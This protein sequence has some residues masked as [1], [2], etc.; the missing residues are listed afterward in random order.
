MNV[1]I[2]T[3]IQPGTS[4]TNRLLNISTLKANRKLY[5][6]KSVANIAPSPK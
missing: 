3:I 6:A 4:I 2:Q 5:V 1:I